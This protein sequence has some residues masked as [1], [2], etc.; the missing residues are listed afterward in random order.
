VM[1]FGLTKQEKDIHNRQL[2]TETRKMLIMCLL[3]TV[4]TG[5]F[6]FHSDT[7]VCSA[8]PFLCQCNKVNKILGCVDMKCAGF[9]S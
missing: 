9:L 4:G 1:A 8:Q 2:G 5:F 6:Q 7:K 3:L